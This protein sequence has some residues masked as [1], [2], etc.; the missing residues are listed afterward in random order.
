VGP[1]LLGEIEEQPSV[2]ARVA[3]S[4]EAATAGRALRRRTFLYLAARGSSD[5]AAT[6]G[7]YLFESHGLAAALAAP[8]LFTLYGSPPDLRRAGVIGISQSGAAPDVAAVLA[9][10]R[11]AGAPTVAV[12][13]MPRSRVAR[14]ARFVVP[15]RAGRERSVA[16]T[17]T[18]TAT[19]VALARLAGAA[20][21]GVADALRAGL[22]LRPDAERLA[23]RIRGQGVAVVGRGYAY[24]SALEVA[25]KVKEL[26]RVW[27]EPYSA[28]DFEHGPIAL[29]GGGTTVILIAARGP[30]TQG[31]R[32]FAARLSRRGSH[33]LALTDDAALADA[34][35]DAALLDA[36][37]AEHLAALALVV[38]GQL[39]ARALAMRRGLD[40]DRP[41]GLRKVTR[42]R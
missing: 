31:L 19:C 40:P 10:G 33:V 26:A 20:L 8:S 17:K 24:A 14:A 15:L 5:N 28:A 1:R 12:T 39:L 3:E 36:D 7:K 29:A 18:Y 22:A 16:A 34:C 30:T 32:A 4:A 2:A 27:A 38:P 9:A 42:T 25:L 21:T 37:A 35:E 41:A 13:N 23:G 11:R 6:Y